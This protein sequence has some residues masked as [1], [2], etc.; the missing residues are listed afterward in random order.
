MDTSSGAA[1]A[2]PTN[3]GVC[4]RGIGEWVALPPTTLGGYPPVRWTQA[5]PEGRAVCLPGADEVQQALAEALTSGRP[6]A[7]QG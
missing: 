6:H 1:R 5:P 3:V 7:D 2:N 4:L